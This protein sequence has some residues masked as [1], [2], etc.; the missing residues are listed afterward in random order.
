MNQ[1]QPAPQQQNNTNMFG[2]MN[3]NGAPSGGN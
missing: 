3:M 1:Q 2:G